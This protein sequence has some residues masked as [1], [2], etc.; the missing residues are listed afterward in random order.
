MTSSQHCYQNHASPKSLETAVHT[1]WISLLIGCGDKDHSDTSI[2]EPDTDADTDTDTE[3]DTDTDAV[4]VL[5]GCVSFEDDTE[6][7]GN[8]RVQLCS[9][10]TGC[11]P[12]WPDADGC[13]F[14]TDN[15]VTE[16]YA[17]DV[18]PLFEDTSIW[19]TPLSI[20]EYTAGGE[21]LTY[22]EPTLIPAF[23][24]VAALES[25][26]FDAGGGLTITADTS[27]FTPTDMEPD[28]DYLASVS[29][30]PDAAGLPLADAPGE[31][32]AMWYLGP[33][34]AKVDSWPFEVAGLDLKAGE[35]LQVYNANYGAYR[36]EDVGTATVGKDG[37]LRT[38]SGAGI[39][40]LSTL[41]L[42]RQ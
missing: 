30:D 4:V 41:I 34:L 11:I 2:Q 15:M 12:A 31:V 17:F 32:A 7:K 42:V 36:W 21:L 5:E 18:V 40:H 13:Y 23:T 10:S 33:A 20:V 8:I 29:V 3:P 39:Q 22:A 37:V 27:T 9:A 6:E 38:D 14:Y 16:T 28:V 25:G 35:Q 19:A 24:H 1:L 26:G